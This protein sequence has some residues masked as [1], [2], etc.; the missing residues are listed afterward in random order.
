[1]SN[2]TIICRCEDV[3]LDDVEHTLGL[4]D[5]SVDE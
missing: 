4:G 5:A 2:K 1:M 3:T